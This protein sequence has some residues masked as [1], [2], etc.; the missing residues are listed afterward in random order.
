M[1]LPGGQYYALYIVFKDGGKLQLTSRDKKS[2]KSKAKNELVGL[3]RFFNK[4]NRVLH[5][6]EEISFYDHRA[7]NP[8]NGTKIFQWNR[9]EVLI[10]KTP[11]NL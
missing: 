4:A 10:N 5:K 6:S 8:D 11:F 2:S 3:K 1:S 7:G 9:G